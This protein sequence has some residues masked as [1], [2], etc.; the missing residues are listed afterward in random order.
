YTADSVQFCDT[1]NATANAQ[2]NGFGTGVCQSKNDF[3]KHKYVKYGQFHRADLINDGRTFP[4]I[5][6]TGTPG[7]R[8]YAQEAVNY[9]NW[10]AYYRTRILAA[11]TV[12]SIAFSFLDNTYRVGFHDLGTSSPTPVIWVDVND[13]DLAQKNLWYNVL[14]SLRPLFG[15]PWPKPFAED[16]SHPIGNTQADIA[17]YYWA[18]DLRPGMINNVPSSSGKQPLYCKDPVNFPCPPAALVPD[19]A[20]IAG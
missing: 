12:S 2:W 19:P 5:D 11:K 20:Q 6:I 10:Y 13:S 16:P 15:K 8:T 4:F 9:G 17:T 7:A 14:P 1:P 18:T 3:S